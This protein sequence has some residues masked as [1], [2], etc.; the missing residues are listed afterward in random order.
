MPMIKKEKIAGPQ[1]CVGKR[2]NSEWATKRIAHKKQVKSPH[3]PLIEYMHQ[4]HRNKV[5]WSG[6]QKTYTQ[7]VAS[8]Y[9]YARVEH[10]G[11]RADAHKIYLGTKSNFL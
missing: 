11:L 10:C 5:T 7:A 8:E 3:C 9:I 1:G 2:S 6:M 4:N